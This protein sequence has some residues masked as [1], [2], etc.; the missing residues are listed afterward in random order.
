MLP[1][2]YALYW[3]NPMKR[4]ITFT[5]NPCLDETVWLEGEREI[6]R[7]YQSGGKGLNVAR[8]LSAL[9]SPA[10][11]M[12]P[13]GGATGQRVAELMQQE[14]ANIL[15]LPCTGETRTVVTHVQKDFSQR[16][17][18][19]PGA[20]LTPGDIEKIIAQ[21]TEQLADCSLLLL[22]GRLPENAL[23][24]GEDSRRAIIEL[25]PTL[26]RLAHE[27]GVPVWLDTH[28]PGFA[29]AFAA[30]PDFLKPNLEEAAE[31]SALLHGSPATNHSLQ[32]PETDQPFEVDTPWAQRSCPFLLPLLTHDPKMTLFITLG[33]LGVLYWHQNSGVF[34]PPY[35]VKTVNPVGSGDS[36]IAGWLHGW[37]KGHTPADCMRLA[38]AAGAVNA[39][40]WAAAMLGKKELIAF[41]ATLAG[42]I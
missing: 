22:S 37:L 8:V 20:L 16:Q 18:F 40:M 24:A 14:G 32:L 26:I 17:T 6:R 1:A 28:G 7:D 39:S 36:F 12:A 41:D 35:Q 13:L 5:P 11:A 21:I 31:L 42:L 23:K 33:E 29:E 34:Y 25:Y 30:G 19:H 2:F 38:Q 27:R 10:V 9:G 4:V 3:E 15:E